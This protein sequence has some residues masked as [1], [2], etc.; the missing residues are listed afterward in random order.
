MCSRVVRNGLDIEIKNL[1][2]CVVIGHIQSFSE[3]EF[4]GKVEIPG[5]INRASPLFL[6]SPLSV[7]TQAFKTHIKLCCPK[8]SSCARAAPLSFAL[9]SHG[10]QIKRPSC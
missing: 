10:L 3:K 2:R 1:W 9:R 4:R 6:E 5:K 8:N 7:K